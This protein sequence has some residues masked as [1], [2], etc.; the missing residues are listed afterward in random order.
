MEKSSSIESFN[1]FLKKFNDISKNGENSDKATSANYSQII[2][3]QLPEVT[4]FDANPDDSKWLTQY[5]FGCLLFSLL[6][7]GFYDAKWGSFFDYNIDFTY[8]S[9]RGRTA[10]QTIIGVVHEY[11]AIL[12]WIILT[13]NN[14]LYGNFKSVR[15]LVKKM[16]DCDSTEQAYNTAKEIK[17]YIDMEERFGVKFDRNNKLDFADGKWQILKRHAEVLRTKNDTMSPKIRLEYLKRLPKYS[18]FFF[19]DHWMTF[20]GCDG[21]EM[22]FCNPSYPKKFSRKSM[23]YVKE[24]ITA[25]FKKI[26]TQKKNL[27]FSEHSITGKHQ[28]ENRITK[29]MLK[30]FNR[31]M[32][33]KPEPAMEL[34]EQE[35]KV[36]EEWARKRGKT[37]VPNHDNRPKDTLDWT[38]DE[39]NKITLEEIMRWKDCEDNEEG[40][41]PFMEGYRDEH[42]MALKIL[43]LPIEADKVAHFNYSEWRN[44][45]NTEKKRIVNIEE[46]LDWVYFGDDAKHYDIDALKEIKN[47]AEAKKV[48]N[49][50]FEEWIDWSNTEKKR[51]ERLEETIKKHK[52]ELFSEL[53]EDDTE[54]FDEKEIGKDNWWTPEREQKLLDEIFRDWDPNE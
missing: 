16:L 12:L 2:K 22:V 4:K 5:H 31:L 44:W 28:R 51:I 27:L 20:L 30:E 24:N 10:K 48:E 13:E 40:W 8:P 52:S 17:K 34:D 49:F 54:N 18:L 47:F 43:N 39:W 37:I 14:V 50:T 33:K 46:A 1:D 9:G 6:N 11:K 35:M 45:E 53:T 26:D 41:T 19:G 38:D 36:L 7:G 32:N 23:D 3:E 15:Q 21:D 42:V 29:K 25:V